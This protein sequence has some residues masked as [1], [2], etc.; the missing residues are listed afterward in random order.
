M[1][2]AIAV[3]AL[4]AAATAEK[5]VPPGNSAATQYTE[6]IPTAGGPKQ[7]GKS[8]HGQDKSPNKVLGARNAHRLDSHGPAGR[9]AAKVAAETAPTATVAAALEIA[10]QEPESKGSS[11]RPD[12][13]KAS[14]P[15]Q[16]QARSASGSSGLS[17]VLAQATG[18]SSSGGTGLLLPLALVAVVAWSL[19]YLARQRKRPVS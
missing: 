15:P 12:G 4:P 18:S 3:V 1:L 6:A 9:A 14:I 7:A 13:S 10:P 11:T 16:T 19:V 17:E 8:K 2:T 5:V